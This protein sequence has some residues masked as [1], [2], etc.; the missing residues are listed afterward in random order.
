MIT[1][2]RQTDGTT[3]PGDED[4]GADDYYDDESPKTLESHW[5]LLARRQSAAHDERGLPR[6]R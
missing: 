3:T 4:F 5:D 6:S 2:N 1:T